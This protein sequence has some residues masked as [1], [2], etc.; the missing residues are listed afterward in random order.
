VACF[1]MLGTPRARLLGELEITIG[2]IKRLDRNQFG[3]AS[4]CSIPTSAC[5]PVAL[6]KKPV[7]DAAVDSWSLGLRSLILA[8]LTCSPDKL[9]CS[10]SEDN[11]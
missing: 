4:F 2:N 6:R 1:R 3:I 11:H 10:H 5:L 9:A 7:W 8:D